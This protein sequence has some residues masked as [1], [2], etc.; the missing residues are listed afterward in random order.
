M[1][2]YVTVLVMK[3]L[4]AEMLFIINCISLSYPYLSDPNIVIIMLM[5]FLFLCPGFTHD[6][7]HVSFH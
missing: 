3:Y 4:F 5:H 7:D 6:Q 2:P 1:R